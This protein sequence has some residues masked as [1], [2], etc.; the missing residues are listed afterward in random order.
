VAGGRLRQS[1]GVTPL[2]PAVRSEERSPPLGTHTVTQLVNA[3]AQRYLRV[4]ANPTDRGAGPVAMAVRTPAAV[5]AAAFPAP[6]PGVAAPARPEQAGSPP[7]ALG[8]PPDLA[9]RLIEQVVRALDAR[10][11]A[12]RERLGGF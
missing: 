6:A 4:E 7:I 9:Q 11:V 8:L 3:V 2:L 5:P 12:A 1:V 10:A